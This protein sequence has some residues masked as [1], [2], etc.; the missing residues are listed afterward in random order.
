MTPEQIKQLEDLIE[1]ISERAATKAIAK[2]ETH[3][4]VTVGRSVLNKLAYVAGIIVISVYF[5]LQSR[6]WL[7]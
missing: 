4:Y 1:T 5:Y 6:G 3:L 7:K 2:L